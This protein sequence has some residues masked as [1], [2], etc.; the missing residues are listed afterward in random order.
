M[1]VTYAEEL[2]LIRDVLEGFGAA[3]PLARTQALWLTEADLR[4]HLSHGIQRVPVIVG[5]MRAGLIAADATPVF[6]WRS[7]SA[8]VVDGRRGFGPVVG[9]ATVNELIRG[10]RA[11]GVAVGAVHDANHLGLLGPYVEEVAAQGLIGLAMTT[12]EALV[13]AWGGCEPVLGTNPIAVGVPAEPEAFVLDMATGAISM[14]KLLAHERT[15]TPLEP[16]WA[17]DCAGAPTMDPA[18]ARRGAISPFGGAKGYALGLAVELLVATLTGTALGNAVR[19]T[20]DTE[21]ETSKG[22]VFIVLDPATFGID[23]SIERLSDYLEEVR[24]SGD[25]E[26]AARVAVPGDRSRAARQRGMLGGFVVDRESWREVQEL[27]ELSRSDHD[28]QRSCS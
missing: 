8:L 6:R 13:H 15:G 1:L 28:L 10:A 5:R 4:G 25:H 3:A 20:L 9:L 23:Y 24:H 21:H 27:L 11:N 12:S 19:G 18:A 17:V 16:G 22:D 2:G 14:G 26:A 7:P